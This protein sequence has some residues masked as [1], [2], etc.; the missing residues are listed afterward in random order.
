MLMADLP[1]GWQQDLDTWKCLRKYRREMQITSVKGYIIG[2]IIFFLI[3]SFICRD[4]ERGLTVLHAS[5][6]S[7]N[8]EMV[9]YVLSF[10]QVEIDALD[11]KGN[12]NN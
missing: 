11:F 2:Q 10:D 4:L 7:E 8:L 5:V 1:P 6:L 9:T 3:S 12:T